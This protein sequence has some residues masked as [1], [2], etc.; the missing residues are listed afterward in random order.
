MAFSMT[1]K[2]VI[3]DDNKRIFLNMD[4]FAETHTIDGKEMP[5]IV[6]NNEMLEREK[7]YRNSKSFSEGIFVK[8]LLV[9]VNAVDF[10][11]MPEVRKMLTFDQK[12]YIVVDAVNEDGIYSISL[13]ANRT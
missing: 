9:Y 10:G 13:E 2:D 5:C 12:K 6:D 4:E 3:E 8:S 7:R 11:D 1:F